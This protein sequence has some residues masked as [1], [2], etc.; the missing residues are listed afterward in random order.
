MQALLL[1]LLSLI[2]ADAREVAVVGLGVPARQAGIVAT[3]SVYLDVTTRCSVS[4][5]TISHAG[6]QSIAVGVE[7]LLHGSA[8]GYF[9]LAILV[10]ANRGGISPSLKL[11]LYPHQVPVQ[12]CLGLEVHSLRPHL[13]AATMANKGILY[14][15]RRVG[16]KP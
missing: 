10:E 13:W 11:L 1:S 5:A 2:E 8:A 15:I 14:H 4:L 7:S 16:R 3:G 9:S 12:L 6:G